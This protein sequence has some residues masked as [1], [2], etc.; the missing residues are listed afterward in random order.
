VGALILEVEVSSEPTQ[1]VC[2]IHRSGGT[3]GPI[4]YSVKDQALSVSFSLGSEKK[5]LR[6]FVGQSTIIALH[7]FVRRLVAAERGLAH[8]E[9]AS[10]KAE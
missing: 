5:N 6:A 1:K 10:P 8:E 4:N 2:K 3:F 9:T 7:T